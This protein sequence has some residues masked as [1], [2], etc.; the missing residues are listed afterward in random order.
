MTSGE[1]QN[2][3]YDYLA[4]SRKVR[5]G[6]LWIRNAALQVLAHRLAP[7]ID[8]SRNGEL[9]LQRT[10]GSCLGIAIDVGA[11]RGEWTGNLLESAPN[12]KRVICY[13]PSSAAQQVLNGRF[14]DEQRVQVVPAAV[15]DDPGERTFFEEAAAGETSSLLQAQTTGCVRGCRVPVVTIDGELARLEI[16][17]VDLLKIDAEG[18]DFHV[19][20]GAERTLR[21]HRASVVQF[22]YG[23]GWAHAGSTLT[24]AFHFLAE[25]EY[26]VFALLPDGLYRYDA[27]CT[28]ELFVYSNFVAIAPGVPTFVNNLRINSE[29]L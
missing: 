8:P 23:G 22:E 18:M 10:L 29:A 17:S 19:L 20:R 15:A 27:G 13:E 5:G 6:A 4:Q 16:E 7:T 9:L 12:V 25:R 24:A 11:N 26:T 14:R 3:L 28:G 2:Q 21:E 1:L